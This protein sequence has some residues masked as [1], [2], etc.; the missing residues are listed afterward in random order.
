MRRNRSNIN[1]HS[2]N[3]CKYLL[4]YHIIFVCKYRKKLLIKHG[5]AIKQILY[6]ISKKYDF[7]I[8]EMEADKDH[9]H[10]MLNTTP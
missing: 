3:H 6:D 4:T 9:I 8:I 1:Y 2:Q 10:I 7:T 5:N